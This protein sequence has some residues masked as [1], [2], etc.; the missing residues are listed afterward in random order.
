M[1]SAADDPE[2]LCYCKTASRAQFAAD[3]TNRPDASF[4]QVCEDTGVGMICTSCLLNAEVVF[5]DARR[6]GSPAATGWPSRSGE[7][8]GLHWPSRGEIAAW[9]VKHSPLV[10]GRFES[11]CPI[12]GADGLATELVVSNA[13]PTSIGPRSARFAIEVEVRNSDGRIAATLD[14]DIRPGEMWTRDLAALLPASAGTR[15][16]SARIALTARDRG[17]KGT[18]RPHFVMRGRSGIAAVHTANAS[19]NHSTPHLF[20]RRRADERHFAHVRNC[21]DVEMTCVARISPES[22]GSAIERTC[23]LPPFGSAMLDLDGP[24]RGIQSVEVECSG[25]QRTWFVTAAADFSKVSVDHV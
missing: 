22:A 17:F 23:T 20:S 14:G 9:L 13:I 1:S 16:G 4:A 25:L 2:L 12:I 3:V 18:V 8:R 5:W 10:P 11:V 19:R 7:S 21:T 24:D 6:S 15:C